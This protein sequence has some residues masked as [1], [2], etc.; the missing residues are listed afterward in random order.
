MKKVLYF[1]AVLSAFMTSCNSENEI[2]DSNPTKGTSTITATFDQPATRVQMGTSDG[3]NT[4]LQWNAGD[5]VKVYNLT[6]E[7]SGIY[8]T[9]SSVVDGATTATFE[10]AT[11]NQII[12]EEAHFAAYPAQRI[13]SNSFR[14]QTTQTYTEN[15]FD[16]LAMP[17]VASN[18]S[19]TE[20][21]FKA[22][23]AV[24]R[25]KVSTTASDVTVSSI[26]ITSASM[27]LTG[28]AAPNMTLG[29]YGVPTTNPGNKVTLN[30]ATPVAINGTATEF[31]IVVPG[32]TYPSG[33]LTITVR[34]NKGK[35]AKTSKTEATFAAGKVYNLNISGAPEENAPEDG[36]LTFTAVGGN[37]TIGIDSWNLQYQTTNQEWTTYTH[38][39]PITI[40]EGQ[41]VQFK[42]A[43]EADHNKMNATFVISSG[44]VEASGSVMSL[45]GAQSMGNYAF[46]RLFKNCTGLK[47]APDLPAEILA[48][49]C[50]NEMFY[51]CTSLETVPE[52]LLPATTLAYCCYQDMFNGCTELTNTPVLPAT[53]LETY[54]YR[55]M[56]K[57]CS[58][59][60][61]VHVRFTSWGNETQ[62]WLDGV[63]DNG[64]FYCPESLYN[65]TGNMSGSNRNGSNVPFEWELVPEE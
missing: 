15:S 25:L 44:E 45:L 32:Q 21:S 50:Y 8:Q 24:L 63:S 2:I 35:I 3:S 55:R 46:Q 30:C 58:S 40:G 9:A 13:Y 60:S 1:A 47:T 56:F 53:T 43:D 18:A 59:L 23:A 26:D 39:S 12:S 37:A 65:I 10:F 49:N 14:Y 51:G 57:G 48:D 20:F 64:T 5:Q 19:G 11:D 29:T 52:E 34:T 17:M 27:A 7:N 6:T 62:D 42:A 31:N 33:D 22:Q 61:E 41:F 38:G 16:R 36:I 28:D 4:P 54:C